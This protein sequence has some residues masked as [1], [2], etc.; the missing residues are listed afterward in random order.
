MIRLS[1]QLIGLPVRTVGGIALGQVSE[2]EIDTETG[3]IK[4]I[5]VKPSG[6]VKGLMNDELII[7][8]SQIIEIRINE[9]LV[10]DIASTQRAEALAQSVSAAPL[11]MASDIPEPN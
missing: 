3:R 2:L 11:A 5:H 6:L 10:E 9:V 7:S 4:N 1:R 8:W